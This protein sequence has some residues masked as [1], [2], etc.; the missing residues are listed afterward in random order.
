MTDKAQ[1]SLN[2]PAEITA[3]WEHG[4][5]AGFDVRANSTEP[6]KVYASGIEFTIH[7]PYAEGEGPSPG[8]NP[9]LCLTW[10]PEFGTQAL[11]D[12]KPAPVTAI[13]RDRECWGGE[14]EQSND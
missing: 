2:I 9:H 10:H 4:W 12:G 8:R 1:T 7:L 5:M 14:K 13:Q 3:G 6:I 11:I